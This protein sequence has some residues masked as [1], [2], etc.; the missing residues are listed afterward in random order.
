MSREAFF[1]AIL[2]AIVWGIVPILEKIG[3]NKVHPDTGLFLR[4]FGVILGAIILITFKFSSL[5][6][7]LAA[8]STKTVLFLVSG[9]FLASFIAQMFFYRA[10]KLGEASVVVPV[11]AIYPLIA[12]ILALIFLGEKFTLTKL[13]GLIFVLLGVMLL[14]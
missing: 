3:L 8:V 2:S 13:F 9:G 1:W 11:A 5:K 10:L 12:F 4:C 6:L 14:K 7:E